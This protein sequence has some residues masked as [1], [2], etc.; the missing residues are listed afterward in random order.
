VKLSIEEF[1]KQLVDAL[2]N[3][4]PG[5]DIEITEMSILRLKVRYHI[6]VSVFIDIFYAVRTEKVSFAVVQKGKRVF[7]IDNL[8]DW[9]CHP[10]GK[11]E[12]HVSIDEP[13]IEEIAAQ[14]TIVIKGLDEEFP[15][16]SH[17]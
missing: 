5:G 17:E 6:A 16:D 2:R 13:S 8:G 7:G 10:F 14:C 1:H 11:P 3:H 4:L 9:H 12:D 15:K